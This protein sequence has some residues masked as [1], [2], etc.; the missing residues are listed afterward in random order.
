MEIYYLGHSSFRIK[1]KSASIVTDPFDP[2]MV[3]LKYQGV[4]G[5]IVT[6]SHDHTDHNQ[7][8]QVS[9]VKKIVTSPGEYEIMGVSIIGLS[10]FHDDA[11]GADR[12]K[13]T[14]YVFEIDEMRI[15]HL[16]DLGHTLNEK[17]VEEIGDI[18]ILMIPTGGEYTINSETAVAVVQG[19]EPRIIIPMHY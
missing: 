11:Q 5:D 15:C 12:G 4:T 17:L 13:N 3:G 1:G 19:I 2:K 6:I 14:I 9:E 18:D 16:G 7:V 10:S 8:S